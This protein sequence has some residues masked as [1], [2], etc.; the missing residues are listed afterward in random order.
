MTSG[1]VCR[2]AWRIGLLAVMAGIGSARGVAAQDRDLLEDQRL[3]PLRLVQQVSVLV[4][5]L[6]P[7]A[8]QVALTREMLHADAAARLRLARLRVA[9]DEA[10]PPFFYVQVSVLCN[11]V[12][13]CAIDVSSAVV[14]DVY[15]LQ[16]TSRASRA[17][18]W[19]TGRLALAPRALVAERVR[20]VVRE[21]ADLFAADV[22]AARQRFKSSDE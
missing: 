10:F 20:D 17:R 13:T 6:T 4:E 14:Q 8:E 19:S 7:D 5:D 12:G 2:R 18:T 1:R 3:T 11:T 21:Q 16:A 15:L 22:L 9:G